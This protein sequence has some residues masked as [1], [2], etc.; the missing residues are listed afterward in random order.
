[1]EPRSLQT[2]W[3]LLLKHTA[4]FVLPER[5]PADLNFPGV[6]M[7]AGQG[8]RRQRDGET[9]LCWNSHYLD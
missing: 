5:S 2:A 6:G 1:M 8:I 9:R 7:T 4:L 3:G